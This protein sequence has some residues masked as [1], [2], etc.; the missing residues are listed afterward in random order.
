MRYR[1][2]N[3]E[4]LDGVYPDVRGQGTAYLL[5]AGFFFFRSC[6][7]TH[8]GDPI[9]SFPRSASENPVGGDEDKGRYSEASNS[10]ANRG[11]HIEGH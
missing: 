3:G 7:K 8:L 6:L 1:V 11:R 5:H 10:R 9:P 4:E 2:E